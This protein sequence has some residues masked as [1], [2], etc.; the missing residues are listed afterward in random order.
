MIEGCTSANLELKRSK[1]RGKAALFLASPVHN[2][3]FNYVRSV[4]LSTGL[5]RCSIFHLRFE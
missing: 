2:Q 4:L 5:V 1:V 3:K